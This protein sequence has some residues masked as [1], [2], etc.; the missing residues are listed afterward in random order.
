ML[1]GWRDSVLGKEFRDLEYLLLGLFSEVPTVPLLRRNSFLDAPTIVRID[2]LPMVS[3]VLGLPFRLL[4]WHRSALLYGKYFLG[5]GRQVHFRGSP[6]VFD[7]RILVD[8]FL[9][10]LK[11]PLTDIAVL[12]VDALQVIPLLPGFCCFL[13]H[14]DELIL[15]L[16]SELCVHWHW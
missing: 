16:E 13:K 3:H 12:E 14:L 8:K 7:L 10:D 2:W 15:K 1:L 9:N 6:F 11:V 4:F 5:S